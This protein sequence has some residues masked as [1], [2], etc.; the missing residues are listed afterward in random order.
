MKSR[1]WQPT[2]PSTPPAAGPTAVPSF[3]R[4]FSHRQSHCSWVQAPQ[5]SAASQACK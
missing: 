2:S 3:L 1:M 4:G 5:T